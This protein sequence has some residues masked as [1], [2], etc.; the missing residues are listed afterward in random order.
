LSAVF[1]KIGS[2]SVRIDWVPTEASMFLRNHW[3]VA[4]MPAEI[5][6]KPLGRTR[7][8]RTHRVLPRRQGQ[9][10][11]LEDWCPHRGAP[12]SLGTV[13][14][15]KLVCG[16]HGLEMGCDGKHRGHARPAGG[17]L[18]GRSQL[19]GDRTPRLRLGVA[20]RRGACRPGPDPRLHWAEDPAGL[21]AAGCTTSTATTG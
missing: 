13:V 12:L 2:N 11:A 16:Y 17:Q 6:D 5:D 8:Q 18:P 14:E 4:C 19:P 21:T 7:V 10:V 20:R 3:Y 1:V 15:G 9:A